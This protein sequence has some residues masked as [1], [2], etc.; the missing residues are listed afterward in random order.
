[1]SMAADF[2]SRRYNPAMPQQIEFRNRAHEVS[3]IEA[4]SDV[5]F[6]FAMTLLVVS[7]E[8]PKNYEEL[9]EMM[10]GMLPFAFCFAIF[11]DIWFEHHNFYRRYALH[12]NVVLA[13][14]TALLFVMLYYVY[15]LKYMFTLVADQITGHVD[16]ARRG[17]PSVL[18]VIYGIGFAAVFWI[19]AAMY[20]RAYVRRGH[21]RLNEVEQID[22]LER[23]ADNLCG[24]AFGVVSAILAQFQP[25]LAGLIYFGI[26][27]PKTLVP[28]YFG[29]KRR[30]AEKRM[31]DQSLDADA[32]PSPA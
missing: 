16:L 13:L 31:L 24:G 23:I 18:F 26:A 1:M 8:A 11:I 19:I 4:F 21:L 32:I 30:V 5:I 14:N 12:D 10:R 20:W 25:T 9:M 27:I 28:I 22:T 3:R 2:T 15:P 29:R 6:G 7:L 17:N